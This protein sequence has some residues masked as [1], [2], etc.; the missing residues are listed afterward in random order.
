MARRTHLALLPPV[1]LACMVMVT[2]CGEQTPGGMSA[3]AQGSEQAA[4]QATGQGQDSSPDAAPDAE[5]DGP[6]TSDEVPTGSDP[7]DPIVVK[8]GEDE[9]PTT[10]GIYRHYD[11]AK[12]GPLDLV[13]P[14][15]PAEEIADGRKQD[16]RDG[17]IYWHPDT[18]AT[19]VRGR[20]LETYHENGG[21]TGRL[22]WPIGDETEEDGIIFS[23]FQ[24]GQIRLEDEAVRVLDHDG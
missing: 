9:Y 14:V 12:G 17:E 5:Q 3:D 19:I 2:A 15:A 16:F 24:H 4:E 18:G 7:E 23:D 21:P 11:A 6:A 1:A 10:M 20:I 8:I 22:G 13:A